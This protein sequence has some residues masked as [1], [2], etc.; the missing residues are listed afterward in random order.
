[1]LEEKT[2]PH[3]YNVIPGGRHDFRV[4]KSDLYHLAQMLLREQRQCTGEARARLG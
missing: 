2:V 1:M 4:W 3:D